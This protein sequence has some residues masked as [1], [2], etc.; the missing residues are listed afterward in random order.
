MTDGNPSN[1][2]RA[3]RKATPCTGAALLEDME[4]LPIFYHKRGCVAKTKQ[5]LSH[6]VELK[7]QLAADLELLASL[8]AAVGLRVR[9]LDGMPRQKGRTAT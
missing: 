6:H 5:E 4:L 8:E 3:K 2:R 9:H 1:K 7:K